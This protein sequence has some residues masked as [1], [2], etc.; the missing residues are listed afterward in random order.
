MDTSAQKLTHTAQWS[1]ARNDTIGWHIGFKELAI[2]ETKAMT[3]RILPMFIVSSI[4]LVGATAC[5][6]TTDMLKTASA[7]H[8]GC[9]PEQ[10]TI[11]N[12]RGSGGGLIW[13]ATC[14]G[15][16][17]LCSQVVT[18]KSDAEYSCAPAQ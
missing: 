18:G 8:T 16:V 2:P 3:S 10:L 1:R 12:L 15:K 7:G 11:S 9:A 14:N 17:Y 4:A 5:V 6:S 13:N